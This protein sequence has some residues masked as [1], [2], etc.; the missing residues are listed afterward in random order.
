[1]PAMVPEYDIVSRS[2]ARAFAFAVITAPGSNRVLDL[3]EKQPQATVPST[4]L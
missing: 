4:A 2:I 3:Q 1:M